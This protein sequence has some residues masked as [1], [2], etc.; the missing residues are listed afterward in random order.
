MDKKKKEKEVEKEKR[1]ARIDRF[2]LKGSGAHRREYKQRF[3]CNTFR[4]PVHHY[5]NSQR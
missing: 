2:E 1:V 5:A 3:A 4:T